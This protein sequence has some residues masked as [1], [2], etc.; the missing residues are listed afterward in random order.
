MLGS[1]HGRPRPLVPALAILDAYSIATEYDHVQ[2]LRTGGDAQKWQGSV[3]GPVVVAPAGL[4]GLAVER[5]ADNNS[6]TC[7]KLVDDQVDCYDEMF[8][9]TGSQFGYDRYSP[10]QPVR[11]HP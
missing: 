5:Q 2:A 3:F 10:V 11:Q 8:D 1:P 7:L 6:L 4:Q 9:G